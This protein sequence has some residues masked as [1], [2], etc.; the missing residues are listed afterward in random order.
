MAGR[1]PILDPRPTEE[2]D[3]LSLMS[4]Q[5]NGSVKYKDALGTLI[6]AAM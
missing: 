3:P 2:Q 4:G 5:L 6:P 1:S